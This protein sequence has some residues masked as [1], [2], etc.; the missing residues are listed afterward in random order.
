MKKNLKA[1]NIKLFTYFISGS[2]F[3]FRT[4]ACVPLRLNCNIFYNSNVVILN[5]L[6]LSF[7]EGRLCLLHTEQYLQVVFR[8][9]YICPVQFSSQWVGF[10]VEIVSSLGWVP[11]FTRMLFTALLLW[12]F[13][14]RVHPVICVSTIFW[15]HH[16][17]GRDSYSCQKWTLSNFNLSIVWKVAVM[18]FFRGTAVWDTCGSPSH[19]ASP[20]S[21]SVLTPLMNV[22][23]CHGTLQL[24]SY[25]YLSFKSKDI[26]S[27]IPT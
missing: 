6:V 10:G 12:W 19:L 20:Y 14:D 27:A 2:N 9:K 1:F 15:G 25:Q 7:P 26:R 23:L 16:S 4:Q 18:G 8:M 17:Q 11:E 21:Y 13:D 3:F 22:G 5:L 24:N